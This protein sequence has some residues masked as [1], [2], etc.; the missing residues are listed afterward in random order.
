M[1]IE[2]IGCTGSG[3][4]TQSRSIVES[5][6]EQGV[7]IFLGEDFVLRQV[8]LNWIK[9]RLP[10]KFAVN[11]LGLF[12]C[13]ITWRSHL[14]FYLFAT[15]LLFQLP[16]ARL[17]KLNL[18]RNV[19]KKVGTNE[20]IRF[21]STDRQIILVDEGV[22]HAAHHL[23]VHSSVQ[24]SE[25]H[26]AIFARLIPFPDAIV[27][28]RQPESLLIDRTL[29]RGHQRIPDHSYSD[30]VRFIHQAVTMFEKLVQYPAVESKLLLIN[31]GQEVTVAAPY[32]DNPFVSLA[33]RIIRQGMTAGIYDLDYKLETN[34]I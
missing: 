18:L 33:S 28:L 7:D 25:E 4:S 3:K 27:Y 12:A 20:I 15:R 24:V 26:L 11:L 30:A 2:I 32:Q 1:V 9:S 8:R 17:D 5:C 14:E 6:H 29:K 21:R 34:Q 19:L 16:I 23:F 22:L 10:R 31:A 13:L